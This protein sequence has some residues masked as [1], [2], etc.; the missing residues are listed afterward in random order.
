M[1]DIMR[2]IILLLM[3]MI[4][5][6]MFN[7]CHISKNSISDETYQYKIYGLYGMDLYTTSIN[8]DEKKN[9]QAEKSSLIN[10]RD[11]GYLSAMKALPDQSV[12]CGFSAMKDKEGKKNHVIVEGKMESTDT[13]DNKM[14]IDNLIVDEEHQ[15]IYYMGTIQDSTQ[16]PK[17]SPITIVDLNTEEVVDTLYYKGELYGCTMNDKY[18]YMT[19][20]L[21]QTLGYTD[22]K[23]AY[24]ARINRETRAYE[25]VT[26][27]GLDYGPIDI[28][29]T[30]NDTLYTIS[31][32]NPR[33]NGGVNEPKICKYNSDG[34]LL[35]EI[36]I[37]LWCEQAVLDEDGLMYINHIGKENMGDYQG[38]KMTIFDTNT[39]KII[40]TVDG[41]KGCSSIAIQDGYIF[42]ANYL[43]GDI[44]ILDKKTRKA[45]GSTKLG[46]T[47]RLE[48]LLIVKNQ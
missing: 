35:C 20:L 15:L 38:Q 31:C 16:S 22:V 43:T 42:V 30:N 21:G 17:G 37:P 7:G 10:V 39:D 40:E 45:I 46:D 34:K 3:L 24:I 47:G 19:I 36:E 32:I 11:I 4:T 1:K 5:C 6:L 2:R 41:F 44:S 8:I 27:E 9:I 14:L 33:K 25:I 29:A 23:E 48:K 13:F 12:I 26:K 18:I 28:C